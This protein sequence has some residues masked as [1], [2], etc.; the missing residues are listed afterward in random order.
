MMLQLN[1][2]EIFLDFKKKSI[3]DRII[4]DIRNL[5]ENEG[6]Y[7]YKPVGVGNFWSNNYIEYESIADRK[8]LSIE[9]I[10][11]RYNKLTQKSDTCK[12]QSTTTKKFVYIN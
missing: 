12:I 5:F 7:Y 11:K 1:I 3:K 6:E 10:I 4:R 2:Q 9:T 8:T